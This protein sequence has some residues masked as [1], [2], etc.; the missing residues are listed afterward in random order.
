MSAHLDDDLRTSL[1]VSP[2]LVA[3]YD[4]L[5][6]NRHDTYAL[7]HTNGRYVRVQ[8]PLD[9]EMVRAH[10]QGRETIALYALDRHGA[11]RWLCFDCDTPDGLAHLAMIQH[12]L[13]DIGVA[14]VREASRRGG[15][16]WVFC[17]TAQPAALLSGLGQ[18]I[19]AVLET[20][21]QLTPATTPIEIYPAGGLAS[22]AMGGGPQGSFGHAVRA[23]FG[24][25]RLTGQRYPFLPENASSL[26]GSPI[27]DDAA[28]QVALAWLVA[29]PRVTSA[30]LRSALAD[31]D[32]ALTAALDEAALALS[33]RLLPPAGHSHDSRAQA[34]VAGHLDQVWPSTSELHLKRVSRQKEHE[35]QEDAPHSR[36][37]SRADRVDVI[38]WVNRAL[39][40]PDLIAE[41][42]P[43]VELQRMG[44]GYGGWCPWHDDQAE[45]ADGTP[46]RPS[47]YVVE[48]WTHG[49]SWRCYS[50][51]CGAHQALMHDTFDWLIW[52]A[53][54]DMQRAISWARARYELLLGE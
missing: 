45:Q 50:T 16:L 18:G 27:K 22:A 43:E 31:L 44:R 12:A 42:T 7:Q 25:H 30:Q 52:R 47:L 19:V 35:P 34:N 48:D 1:P 39:A 32:A 13:A 53:G 3:A 38:A 37:E 10:L 40:L 9:A 49:W 2:E 23:P 20:Q 54:G 5:L 51:Q 28:L 21:G 26:M 8:R 46:G 14:A 41:V 11:G 29:Q 4:A 15:H 36:R 24:V 17:T 33:T 6:V